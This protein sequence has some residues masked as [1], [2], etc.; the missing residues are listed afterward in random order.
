MRVA[1][2]DV[3]AL[4]LDDAVALPSAERATDGVQRRPGHFRQV[5]TGNREINLDTV[6]DLATRL[7]DQTQNGIGDAL[8]HLLRRELEYARVHF[9]KPMPDNFVGFARKS[10]V[11]FDEIIPEMGRPGQGYR[12]GR[13]HGCG[14]IG[15]ARKGRG[16][17]KQFTTGN[18]QRDHSF[19]LLGYF[20]NAYVSIQQHEK[21][22]CIMAFCKHRSPRIITPRC[23]VI[24]DVQDLFMSELGK[25]RQLRQQA[26][27]KQ[28]VWRG[29][30]VVFHHPSLTQSPSKS[31]RFDL[32]QQ[33]MTV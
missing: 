14:G 24:E 23:R 9:L 5:L 12:L 15:R 6:A 2:G 33:N 29:A 21:P 8:A 10:G 17:A 32:N 26:R 13:G 18:V 11:S 31:H 20:H 28:T 3:F 30:V 19:P 27:V 7:V 16:D 22:V 4:A 25:R 1:N